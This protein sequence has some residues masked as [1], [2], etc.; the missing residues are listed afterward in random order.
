MKI[1][2]IILYDEPSI[3][4]I[5]IKEIEKFLTDTFSVKVEI[6]GNFIDYF[7]NNIVEKIERTKVLD[8]K[9]TISKTKKQT[10]SRHRQKRREITI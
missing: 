5:K 4:E 6:R 10:K 3:P 9:K 1:S 8:T 2:K 7:K